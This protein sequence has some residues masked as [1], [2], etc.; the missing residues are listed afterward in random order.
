MDD[1]ATLGFVVA[2]RNVTKPDSD[3]LDPRDHIRRLED[4]KLRVEAS[5]GASS[6]TSTG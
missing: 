3:N 5:A 2:A 6:T 4:W 1:Y